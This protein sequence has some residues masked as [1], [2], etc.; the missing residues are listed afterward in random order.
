MQERRK[1]ITTLK[2]AETR[3][4]RLAVAFFR[5]GKSCGLAQPGNLNIKDEE[6]LW[7]RYLGEK[8]RNH[9][10]ISIN[11]WTWMPAIPFMGKRVDTICHCLGE[12]ARLNKEIKAD[13]RELMRLD[14]DQKELTEL[15]SDRRE[16]SKY[17]QT[18]SAF[19]QFNTQSAAYMACQTLLSFS[20]VHLSA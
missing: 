2:V 16:S 13:Q 17:P 20:P 1:L 3:L 19:I 15:E 7:K 5:Q 11:G 14:G 8:D 9:M 12:L 10:Y 18:K 4:I 6:P